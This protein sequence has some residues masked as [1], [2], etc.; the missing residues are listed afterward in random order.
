MAFEAARRHADATLRGR[1][2]PDNRWLDARYAARWMAINGLVYGLGRL[3][4]PAVVNR[5]GRKQPT[6]ND[7]MEPAAAP[8]AAAEASVG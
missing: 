3:R 7:L 6:W 1:L 4:P 5:H 2:E 8:G